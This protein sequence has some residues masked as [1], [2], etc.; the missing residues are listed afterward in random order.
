MAAPMVARLRTLDRGRLIRWRLVAGP[1]AQFR[2]ADPDICKRARSRTTKL[3]LRFKGGAYW[4]VK[5]RHRYEIGAEL[6]HP[7]SREIRI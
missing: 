7:A 1:A 5:A 2:Y 6:C 4:G 3:C